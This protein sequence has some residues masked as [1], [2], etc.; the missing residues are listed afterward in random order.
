MDFIKYDGDTS[1]PAGPSSN[2]S[3]IGKDTWDLHQL[4]FAS[5]MTRDQMEAL[6]FEV[7]EEPA[8]G[9][10]VRL[11]LSGGQF[12][13]EFEEFAGVLMVTTT[14][15]EG[16]MSFGLGMRMNNVI[17]WM[18]IEG[19]LYFGNVYDSTMQGIVIAGPEVGE[20]WFAE[21]N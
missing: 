8:G 19:A 15:E 17:F 21:E 9:W 11:P 7:P 6:G 4:F 13:V 1:D 14:P 12:Q 10:T 2:W 5:P 3:S 20:I 18:N 16:P